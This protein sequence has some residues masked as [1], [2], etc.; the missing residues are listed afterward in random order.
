MITHRGREGNKHSKV[1]GAAKAGA[2]ARQRRWSG[3]APARHAAPFGAISRCT[4][5]GTLAQAEGQ[6]LF[7]PPFPELLTVPKVTPKFLEQ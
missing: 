3:R 6:T 7:R 2:A 1:G 5:V 4:A